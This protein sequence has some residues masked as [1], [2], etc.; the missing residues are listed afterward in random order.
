MVCTGNICRSPMAEVLL[1]D[2]LRKLGLEANVSSAGLR[3]MV[4]APADPL[5]V[6]LMQQR[7]LD[8]SAH[9]GRQLSR[10]IIHASDLVLV[11]E[12]RQ[13]QLVEGLDASA[14]GRVHRLGRMGK[15]DVPDPYRR[16]SQAF[17]EALRLIDKGLDEIVPVFWRGAP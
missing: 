9:R 15:F 14:R 3:A 8:L 4:G 11:M 13:K 2:R 6:E 12:E 17:D 16:G 1:A 10:E 5:A 7:G